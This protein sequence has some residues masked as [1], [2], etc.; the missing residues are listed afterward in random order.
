MKKMLFI[1]P[2]ILL[3][4]CAGKSQMQTFMEANTDADTKYFVQDPSVK[5]TDVCPST[6]FMTESELISEFSKQIKTVVCNEKKC[7]ENAKSDNVIVIAPKI[8]YRKTF[9]GEGVSCNESYA[10]SSTKYSFDLIKGGKVVY[11]KPMSNELVPQRSVFGNLGRIATQLSFS[12]GPENEKNDIGN[13]TNGIAERI[14][15][16]LNK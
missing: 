4:A 16:D 10:N 9:M 11:T 7:A 13:H 3:S 1:V 14:L 5:L 2:V 15:E 8:E 6:G 12:G